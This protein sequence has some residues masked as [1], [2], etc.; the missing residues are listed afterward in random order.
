MV[1]C[2]LSLILYK[3]DFCSKCEKTAFRLPFNFFGC[4]VHGRLYLFGVS[5][6]TCQKSGEGKNDTWNGQKRLS[7]FEVS[8]RRY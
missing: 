6:E 8:Q 5:K 1:N 4:S 7:P 2:I 3:F